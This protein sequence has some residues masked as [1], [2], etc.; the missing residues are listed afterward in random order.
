MPP[1][2]ALANLREEGGYADL[3]S[4]AGHWE[5]GP[6]LSSVPVT[7]FRTLYFSNSRMTGAELELPE[8]TNVLRT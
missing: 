1:W 3:I 6:I 8:S 5:I 7:Y 2:H 4:I